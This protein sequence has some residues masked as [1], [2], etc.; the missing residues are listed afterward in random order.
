[1]TV[2]T[3]KVEGLLNMKKEELM[4]KKVIFQTGKD[5]MKG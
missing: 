3:K 5:G 1:M 2:L 4:R